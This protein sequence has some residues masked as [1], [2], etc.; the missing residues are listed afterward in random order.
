MFTGGLG[1]EVGTASFTTCVDPDAIEVESAGGATF[2]AVLL[3]AA[4]AG[5][6]AAGA[7]VLEEVDVLV[8]PAVVAAIPA[9]IPPTDMATMDFIFLCLASDFF[10][11]S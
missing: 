4:G 7:A 10:C 1:T 9:A 11:M 3:A 5:S 8:V 2:P 6:A